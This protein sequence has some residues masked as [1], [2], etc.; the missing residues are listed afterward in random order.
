[1]GLERDKRE[2]REVTLSHRQ[3]RRAVPHSTTLEA[4]KTLR[5]FSKVSGPSFWIRKTLFFL[6]LMTPLKTTDSIMYSA[7]TT[8][9]SRLSDQVL[10][11]LYNVYT[12]S[13]VS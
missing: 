8:L 4:F 11:N 3:Q 12:P 5:A 13:F 6:F 1:M 2:E 9:K 10:Y 7:L